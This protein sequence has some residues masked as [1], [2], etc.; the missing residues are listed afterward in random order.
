VFIVGTGR[1]GTNWLALMLKTHPQIHVTVE[2]EPMFGWVTAMAL[3]PPLRDGLYPRLARRYALEHA[4]VRTK[5]YVD[6][7]HPNLWIADRLAQSF[8]SAKF[9]AIRRDVRAVVASMLQHQGVMASIHDWKRYPVPND[10]LGI[11]VDNVDEYETLSLAAKCA[12]RWL[13][14]TQ[15]IEKLR[16]T[17]GPR[18]L[19]CEY[20]DLSQHSAA[21]LL[22]LNRF[23]DLTTPLATPAIKHASLDQWRQTLRAADLRDIDRVVG[24]ERYS[25]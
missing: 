23:L 13:S 1:S 10:L 17:L 8:P 24:G 7:S 22:K 20:E 11:T 21:V 19:V 3:Q 12:H 14:H 25:A 2:K 9:I 16:P 15:R 6:K 5:I 4:L 18:L